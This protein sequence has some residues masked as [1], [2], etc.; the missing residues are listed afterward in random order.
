MEFVRLRSMGVLVGALT[1]VAV[2]AQ[3]KEPSAKEMFEA[4][5]GHWHE[6][7][8]NF[9]STAQRC[10]SGELKG[11]QCIGPATSG[12]TEIKVLALDKYKCVVAR[13]RNGHLHFQARSGGSRQQRCDGESS[14]RIAQR[15]KDKPVPTRLRIDGHRGAVRSVVGP[16]TRTT[17]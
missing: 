1:A 14:R 2:G 9:K 16:P 11:L 5:A 13:D 6:V 12:I 15:P 8:K 3:D 7:S 10:K 17:A 4:Y